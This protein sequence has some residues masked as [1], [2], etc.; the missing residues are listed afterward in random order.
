M[1]IKKRLCKRILNSFLITDVF[2][3]Q[4]DLHYFANIKKRFIGF[5]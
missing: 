1:G 5:K 4:K 2:I 3:K